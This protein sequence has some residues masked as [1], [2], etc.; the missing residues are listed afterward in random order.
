MAVIAQKDYYAYLCVPEFKRNRTSTCE[1]NALNVLK[2]YAHWGQITKEDY[3]N[4]K[5]EIKSAPH[6]DAIS[7]IM[8]RLRKRIYG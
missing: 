1:E 4:L 7:D 5:K 8:T 2:D 3:N 6:N